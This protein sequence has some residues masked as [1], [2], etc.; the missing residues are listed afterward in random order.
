M[1]F[2]K[3]PLLHLTAGHNPRFWDLV[4]SLDATGRNH[5]LL[6]RRVQNNVERHGILYTPRR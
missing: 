1:P 3:M 6:A 5:E 2:D 4:E